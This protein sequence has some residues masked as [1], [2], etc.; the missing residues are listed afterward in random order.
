[1]STMII[2]GMAIEAK[3]SSKILNGLY[4]ILFVSESNN[5]LVFIAA[6]PKRS[7]GR[8]Y[9]VGPKIIDLDSIRQEIS[10]HKINLLIEGITLRPD[11]LA[12]DDEL[13]KKYKPAQSRTSKAREQRNYR[14]SMIEPLVNNIENRI[15]LFDNQVRSELIL[16]RALEIKSDSC[17]LART[18]KKIK[19]LLNQF[20]AEGS[21]RYAL[22]PYVAAQGGRG[23]ERNQKRKLGRKN[24]RAKNGET[25]LAGLVM[26]PDDKDICG[27]AWRN[28]YVRGTSIDKA[29]RKMWREFYSNFAIDK[30]GKSTCTLKPAHQRPSI[31]QFTTWGNARSPGQT[32]WQKQ[33]T[34][35]NLNRLDRVLFGSSDQDIISVGQL[36]A[37]DSTSIDVELVSVTNRLKRIGSAH[38]IL[39]V[40][41]LYGYI[42]GFYLG[43]EAPSAK[44]VALAFLHSMTD[45]TEWLRWLGLDE[46][47]PDDWIPI[48]YGMVN[49]DNTD[50]R[51]EEI[52]E[53][54][55]SIN[56]GIKFVGVARSDLNSAVETS[57]HI[58]H[59]MVDHN[60]HGTTRGQRL[61]RGEEQ[62]SF[63]ARH[64]VIE[65][66]RETARAIHLHNTIELDIQPTLEMQ[67]ELVSKGIKITRANLTRWKMNQGKC[68]TSL[69]SLNETRIKLLLPIRGT[70]T[71][72]GVQLLRPDRGN[73]REFIEQ[74]RYISNH[75]AVIDRVK[76]SKL[77]RGSVIAESFD[78]DFLHNPYKPTEI[79][80][81]DKISG[82]LIK[83]ELVSKDIDLPYECSLP[84]IMELSDQYA[85]NSHQIKNSRDEA[86]SN[87]EYE[88]ELTK[89]SAENEYRKALGKEKK[90]PSKASLKRDK[91]FNRQ[92]EKENSLYGMPIQISTSEDATSSSQLKTLANDEALFT[93]IKRDPVA[94]KVNL[95]FKFDPLSVSKQNLVLLDAILKR[96]Q[97]NN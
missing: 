46:Q 84:D 60:L 24:V 94:D 62:P 39:I 26:T 87:L 82:E 20:F 71:Q 78:D 47:D 73:K 43:L 40:D 54:L 30:H 17:S 74:I 13:D 67:R 52:I 56:T 80:Y 77:G 1:M 15:L 90:S 37:V 31:T 18:I 2:P 11:V 35:F 79:F 88:Q 41:S 19:E 4:N 50:A 66:I 69:L 34:Q 36:G 93:Q 25:H 65:S 48:R 8:L 59:R 14:Y 3:S 33:Q 97:G 21:T 12:T 57:H 27:F 91:K 23:K 45:K 16:K 70:F 81:R 9:F 86:L 44:T 6:T 29:L 75:P 95:D 68:F 5:K 89:Q 63:L 85:A 22:T 32:S 58:L 72:Y 92:Q 61:E 64:T 76:K 51:C 53:K 83:L 28:Y 55:S 10:K 96:R 49:A 38:R 42:S 7:K